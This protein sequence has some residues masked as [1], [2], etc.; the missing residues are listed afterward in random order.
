MS[1]CVV[2]RAEMDSCCGPKEIK[3]TVIV[4]RDFGV[5]IAEL[6]TRKTSVINVFSV[7]HIVWCY[8]LF[9]I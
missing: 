2:G 4:L 3:V 1:I 7:Q 6:L 5:R 8:Y 9:A